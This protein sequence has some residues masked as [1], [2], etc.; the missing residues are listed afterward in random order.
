MVGFGDS[1]EAWRLL[2]GEERQYL[3][4]HN[5]QLCQ[6]LLELCSCHLISFGEHGCGRASSSPGSGGWG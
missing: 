6:R 1:E 4:K 5:T 2:R 3:Y